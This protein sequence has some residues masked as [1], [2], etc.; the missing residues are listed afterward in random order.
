[1]LK[2]IMC[3]DVNNGIGLNNSLPWRVKEEMNNF[4]S[5][6]K[7][8]TVVMGWKTF[9]SLNYR[10]LK[11]R[12]NI[13]LSRKTRDGYDGVTFVSDYKKIIELSKEKDVYVIGGLKIYKLFED[14]IDEFILSTLHKSYKCDTHYNFSKLFFNLSSTENFK[15]FKLEI[16][17]R[18][19][20]ILNGRKYSN[21]IIESI[22]ED[23]N[24][25]KINV[26][27]NKLVI[28]QVGDDYASK[29]YVSR[30]I[31]IANKIGLNVI[32]NLEPDVIT[33]KELLRVISQYN[34]DDTVSGII[35]QH[36]LPKIISPSNVSN[37]ISK[38]K[39]VDCFSP[40][41][42]GLMFGGV[43]NA[44]IPC[45][46]YGIIKLLNYYDINLTSKK[47]TIIGRSNIVGKPLSILML[48]EDATV[49]VCHSKTLN[50]KEICLNSDIIISAV[51]SPNLI[52]ASFVNKDAICI[53]VGINHLNGK[54]CGDFDFKSVKDKCKY[55]TP[56]PFGIG[57]MTI[58]I[59]F[60]NFINLIKK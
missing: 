44:V 46:P 19:K 42:L 36:P 60:Q 57:P 1:M 21:E 40:I 11:N 18:N 25:Y 55:I 51:G 58:A 43:K 22:K 27:N 50:L 38:N 56:V 29:I 59:L 17:Q 47:V 14:Y 16:W 5:K 34:D 53:D 37:I 24:K 12:E 23:I 48:Q 45:T 4:V 54:I 52:D 9:E 6:T 32:H 39:D 41:N 26:D 13:V 2:S 28:I 35:V 3:Q 7:G 30:K 8:K 20:K 49:T 10:P 31:N 33:E 15:E